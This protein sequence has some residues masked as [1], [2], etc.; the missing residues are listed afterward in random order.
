MEEDPVGAWR[1]L[2]DALQA[3]LDDPEIAARDFEMRAGRFTVEVAINTFCLGDVLV[4]T[5]DLVR[6][7]RLD[8]IL[9]ADADAD[10]A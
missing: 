1:V 9:D 4:H 2:S 5:W 6:A 7:T 8:E 10:A 3:A